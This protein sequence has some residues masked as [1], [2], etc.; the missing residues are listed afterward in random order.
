LAALGVQT[1]FVAPVHLRAAEDVLA[2][3]PALL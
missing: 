2:W 1:V 3:A